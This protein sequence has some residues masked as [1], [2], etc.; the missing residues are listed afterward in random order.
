MLTD[1]VHL[2]ICKMNVRYLSSLS[3][4]ECL[5]KM[6]KCVPFCS[7]NP[8][9]GSKISFERRNKSSIEVSVF[10]ASILAIETPIDIL[11]RGEDYKRNFYLF[12]SF[13]NLISY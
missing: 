9:L 4:P 10:H 3:Y 5:K 13:I 12:Y 6:L 11:K 7:C 8:P 2:R 1:K